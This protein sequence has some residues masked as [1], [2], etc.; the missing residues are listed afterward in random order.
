[1]DDAVKIL[2]IDD[3]DSGREAL[4]M[5]LQ[6][7]GYVVTAAATGESALAHIA[8]ETYQVIVSDLFLPDKSGFDILESLE[9]NYPLFY[10]EWLL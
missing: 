1:M 2:V 6:S 8:L 4:T 7:A 10:M 5:L 3:D 9:K